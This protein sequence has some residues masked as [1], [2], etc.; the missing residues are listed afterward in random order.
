MVRRLRRLCLLVLVGLLKK[1][2]RLSSL[3]EFFFESLI[4]SDSYLSSFS[5][6]P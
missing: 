2:T 1:A 5:I 3:N 4:H 6:I